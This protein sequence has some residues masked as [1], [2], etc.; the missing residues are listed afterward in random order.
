MGPGDANTLFPS[1]DKLTKLESIEIWGF[2]GDHGFLHEI[3]N[4]KKAVVGAKTPERFLGLQGYFEANRLPD[5][6]KLEL[7]GPEDF[8]LR[9]DQGPH[10]PFIF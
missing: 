8:I 1:G 10:S 9:L 7:K 3:R 6:I 2:T 5:H 4:L